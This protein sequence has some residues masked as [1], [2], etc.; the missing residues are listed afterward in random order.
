MQ[1]ELDIGAMFASA[2]GTWKHRVDGKSVVW[3]FPHLEA[4]VRFDGDKVI[5]V[6]PS[7]ET[8]MAFTFKAK[9]WTSG[10]DDQLAV[11]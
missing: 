8:A 3:A 5:H 4:Q 11:F 1:H 7:G 9:P 6:T 2:S 10:N